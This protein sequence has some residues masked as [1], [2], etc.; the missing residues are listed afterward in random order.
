MTY[1]R[2][3]TLNTR[4]RSRTKIEDS[5]HRLDGVRLYHH[6]FFTAL[7][8]R[9]HQLEPNVSSTAPS[10]IMSSA[11]GATTTQT[12]KQHPLDR[13]PRSDWSEVVYFGRPVFSRDEVGPKCQWA[14]RAASQR[15]A[16]AFEAKDLGTLDEVDFALVILDKVDEM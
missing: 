11:T 13:F 14:A 9:H 6:L 1:C 10:S 16:K 4:S 2:L 15:W 8:R 7:L 5:T 12:R 3:S